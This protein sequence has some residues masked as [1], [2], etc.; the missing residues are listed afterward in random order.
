MENEV[1]YI[2][3]ASYLNLCCYHVC[4][5][6]PVRYF[7]SA[8]LFLII[9]IIFS[10]SV[11]ELN[12]TIGYVV[13]VVMILGFVLLAITSL[14]AAFI[15]ECPFYSPFSAI[16]RLLFKFIRKHVTWKEG[17]R[18][19]VPIVL[20]F[21]TAGVIAYFTLTYSENILPLVFIPLTITFSYA[22]ADEDEDKEDRVKKDKVKKKNSR[23]PQ[24]YRL[25]HFALGGFV[26]IGSIL[27]AAG[28]FT[29]P[30]SRNIFIILYVIGMSVLFIV[31]LAARYLAKSSKKTMVI[32][33][34]A[35]LLN[36]ESDPSKIEPLLQRIGQITFD[37][38]EEDG[39][40]HYR[41]RLLE[42]LMPLLSSLITSPRTKM[43]YDHSQLKDLETYVSS[44]AQL[45]DFKD[46]PFWDRRFLKHLREDAKR[47][48]ILEYTLRKK[49]VE[50]I[51]DSR[52]KDLTDAA[53]AVLRNFGLDKEKSQKQGFDVLDISDTSSMNTL[54]EPE[55]PFNGAS[56]KRHSRRKKGYNMLNLNAV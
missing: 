45:S 21:V 38:G 28:Y 39:Y 16:I 36:S 4:L 41:A 43:L 19:W 7:T 40:N 54:T 30:G 12:K 17:H 52:S 34:M 24:K 47:H 2:H 22:M 3:H 37:N 51:K 49:L 56:L 6:Y 35:W 1:R 13:A 32:D 15:P 29:G 8:G 31:G 53:I 11:V 5:L 55:H 33:A 10:T 42:S 50:L 26:I 20:C 48:P 27:A 14:A 23:K 18:L 9:N 46:D 44:L 25:P